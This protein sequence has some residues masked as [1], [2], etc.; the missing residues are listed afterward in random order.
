MKHWGK[1]QNDHGRVEA[2]SNVFIAELHTI[3]LQN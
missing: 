2:E 1:D 3:P